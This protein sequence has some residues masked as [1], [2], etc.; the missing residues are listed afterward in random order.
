[1][2]GDAKSRSLF[3]KAFHFL[4][5]MS[6]AFKKIVH[7]TAVGDFVVRQRFSHHCRSPWQPVRRGGRRWT[8]RLS[9]FHLSVFV[10]GA[11][12]SLRDTLSRMRQH[13]HPH[14]APFHIFTSLS[15]GIPPEKVKRTVNWSSKKQPRR[16]TQG[17]GLAKLQLPV[18]P[19][20]DN[21]TDTTTLDSPPY[22]SQ[23]QNISD[24]GGIFRG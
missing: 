10:S 8:R 1:M 12:S 7:K 4:S 15:C 17:R 5:F 23:E 6:E 3:E 9:A 18:S 2:V 20:L 22:G 21:A 13:L 19:A 14:V 11:S 24:L 16:K